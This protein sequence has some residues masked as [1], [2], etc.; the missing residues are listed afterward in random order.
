LKALHYAE[1]QLKDAQIKITM[2]EQTLRT[3]ESDYNIQKIQFKEEKDKIVSE[4]KVSLNKHEF[5]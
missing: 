4:L 3:I 2:L 1:G 5:I